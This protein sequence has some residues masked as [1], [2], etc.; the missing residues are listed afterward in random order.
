MAVQPGLIKNIEDETQ[1]NDWLEKTDD[2]VAVIDCFQN[3]CGPC[4]T[5]QPTFNSIFLETTEPE[6]RLVF[7]TVRGS[8]CGE[9]ALLWDSSPRAGLVVLAVA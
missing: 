9:G 7:L 2:M 6:D 1:F 8:W 5:L 3:W 4:E